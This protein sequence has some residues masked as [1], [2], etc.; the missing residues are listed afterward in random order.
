MTTPPF[1]TFFLPGPTEVR[2]EVLQAMSQPMISHRRPEF[3]RLFEHVQ[4]GLRAVFSTSRPVFIGTCSATGFMEAGVRCAP[5]GAVLALVNGAFSERFAHIAEACGRSVDRYAVP[6]GAVHD[7]EE[8]AERLVAGDYSTVTVVHSETSTGALNDIRAISNIAHIYGSTCLIDSVSG[9]GGTEI[10]FD[11]WNLDYV[12]TGSQKAIA[13]PP[14]LAF[15]VA[16]EEFMRSATES[17]ARAGG[18]GAYFDLV[19]FEDFARKRQVPTTPALSLFYAL[20]AQTD[21]I[22]AEGIEAR[23]MRHSAM[24]ERTQGWVTEV[25]DTCGIDIRVLAVDGHRSP[26]VTTITLPEGMRSGRVVQAV[27][28]RGFTIGSGSGELKASTIR[29]GHMGDHTLDTLENCL[30]ACSA[31]LRALL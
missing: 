27:T 25:R 6:W 26:T 4:V 2:A 21:A 29:I 20:A 7:P 1:G 18:R 12:L 16:S 14:G 24:A 22:M 19:D 10:R 17:D 9:A 15:A 23:W 5:D 3:E 8:V 28:E 11:D 13:L 30:V 31:A